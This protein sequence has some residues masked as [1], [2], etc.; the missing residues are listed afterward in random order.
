MKERDKYPTAD[1]RAPSAC[2]VR[3]EDGKGYRKA[4]QGVYWE[5]MNSRD[6]TDPTTRRP[7]GEMLRNGFRMMQDDEFVSESE[8][9]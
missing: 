9:A 5:G 7:V 6:E 4:K 1:E 8:K 2:A 3:T